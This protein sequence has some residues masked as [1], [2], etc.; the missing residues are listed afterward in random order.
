MAIAEN[1]TASVATHA[2]GAN[3]MDA[4]VKVLALPALKKTKVVATAATASAAVPK[5]VR[6]A[7]GPAVTAPANAHR[8]TLHSPAVVNVPTS[9]ALAAAPASGDH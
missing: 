9:Y 4:R 6:G 7:D 5:V 3:G 8:A 2:S 1:K